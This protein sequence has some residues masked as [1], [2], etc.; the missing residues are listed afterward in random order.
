[1]FCPGDVEFHPPLFDVELDP[2]EVL[3]VVVQSPELGVC[4]GVGVQ[5]VFVFEPGAGVED[6]VHELSLGCV[7]GAGGELV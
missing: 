7:D 3:G 2:V 4:V 5:S 1:M 6:G